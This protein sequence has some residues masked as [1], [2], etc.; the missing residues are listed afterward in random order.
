M[1]KITKNKLLAVMLTRFF[2]SSYGKL[3]NINNLKAIQLIKEHHHNDNINKKIDINLKYLKLD[4]NIDI[5]KTI[6]DNETILN[7]A[8]K[9][10]LI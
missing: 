4:I 9:K 7:N 1:C 10:Y 5:N 3:Y 6:K 8:S 2:N